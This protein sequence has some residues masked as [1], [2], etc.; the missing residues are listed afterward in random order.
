MSKLKNLRFFDRCFIQRLQKVPGKYIYV[1]YGDINIHIS[2]Q[3]NCNGEDIKVITETYI[4]LIKT[5]IEDYEWVNINYKIDANGLTSFDNIDYSSIDYNKLTY[6]DFYIEF[7]FN[8]IEDSR[9]L[10]SYLS[11]HTIICDEVDY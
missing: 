3:K 11:T 2:F 6:Y 7:S 8:D 5:L 4:S 1:Y 10:V 9:E